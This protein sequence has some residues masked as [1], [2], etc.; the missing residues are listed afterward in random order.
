MHVLTEIVD[1]FASRPFRELQQKAEDLPAYLLSRSRHLNPLVAAQPAR[2]ETL[3][4]TL[5]VQN[6]ERRAWRDPEIYHPIFT[7]AETADDSA[8]TESL[9][10]RLEIQLGLRPVQDLWQLDDGLYRLAAVDGQT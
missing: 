8:R 2:V 7:L 9:L 6:R 3:A 1:H 10:T 5:S 4:E